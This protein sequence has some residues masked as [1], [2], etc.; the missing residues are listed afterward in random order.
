M[1]WQVLIISHVWKYANLELE[2][3]TAISIATAHYN[4]LVAKQV[5]YS[6][7]YHHHFHLQLS[8]IAMVRGKQNQIYR[9]WNQAFWLEYFA[10][11]LFDFVIWI[12]NYHQ[13]QISFAH[14]SVNQ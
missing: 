5:S 11:S 14:N 8:L 2:A 9:I 4:S 12:W 7:C 6:I 10:L 1:L 13:K 3:A